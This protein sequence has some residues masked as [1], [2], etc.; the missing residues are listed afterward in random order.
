MLA[1]KIFKSF[2]NKNLN[3]D[4]QE[5]FP[6]GLEH[7]IPFKEQPRIISNTFKGFLKARPPK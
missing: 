7:K 4:L 2:I 3:C 5:E 6:E 1:N